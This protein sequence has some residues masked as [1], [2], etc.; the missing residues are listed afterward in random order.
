MFF[1]C[2]RRGDDGDVKGIFSLV[3]ITI[4]FNPNIL[5]KNIE[6]CH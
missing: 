6:H 3:L 5:R 4:Q 1:F 2:A